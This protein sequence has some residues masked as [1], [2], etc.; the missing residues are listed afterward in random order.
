LSSPNISNRLINRHPLLSLNIS[1]RLINRHPLPNPNISR[2]PFRLTPLHHLD[3]CSAI[4]ERV[5]NI[6]Y[7]AKWV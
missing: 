3:C 7:V 5:E 1:N 2:L 6:H 4:S